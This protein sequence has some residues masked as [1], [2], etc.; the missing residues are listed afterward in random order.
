LV[1]LVAAWW[2]QGAALGLTLQAL[3]PEP[4][5]WSDWPLWTGASAVSLVGGFLAFFTPGGLGVRE[6]LLMEL[7]RHHVGAH[8]AVAA[9]L[10]LRVITLVGEL[11][12]SALLYALVRRPLASRGGR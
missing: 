7:L 3:S 9:A 11:V 4:V 12:A 5:D 2:L 1:S 10:V 6:G 8:E